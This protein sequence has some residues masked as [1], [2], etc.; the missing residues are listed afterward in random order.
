M[1]ERT[2]KSVQREVCACSQV[3]DQGLGF[4][5]FAH[6]ALCHG[7]RTLD[8]VE[9]SANFTCMYVRFAG[10]DTLL[11]LALRLSPGGRPGRPL[12]NA[13]LALALEVRV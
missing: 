8:D 5:D 4:R 6:D 13:I 10:T 7:A 12:L 3:C 2:S 9:F 11:A 1:I